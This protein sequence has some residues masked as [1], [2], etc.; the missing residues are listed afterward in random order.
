MTDQEKKAVRSEILKFGPSPYFPNDN[1]PL[2]ALFHNEME[3]MVG[4]VETDIFGQVS[5][6]YLILTTFRLILYKYNKK[7]DDEVLSFWFNLDLADDP[8]HDTE[9]FTINRVETTIPE[10]GFDEKLQRPIFTWQYNFYNQNNVKK[11]AANIKIYPQAYYYRKENRFLDVLKPTSLPD[12][13]WKE[14][15]TYLGIVPFGVKLSILRQGPVGKL[16]MV[17]LQVL[18]KSPEIASFHEAGEVPEDSPLHESKAKR[19]RVSINV[20]E[21]PQKALP[22]KKQPRRSEKPRKQP[23]RRNPK[24]RLQRLK[25]VRQKVKINKQI[26]KPGNKLHPQR[27]ILARN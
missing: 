8:F 19:D 17:A 6:A 20:K 13:K 2:A 16:H 24:K 27:L 18:H 25:L 23:R 12:F 10:Y 3:D 26:K 9:G 5:T 1:L 21:K 22:N 14:E 4:T 15:D 11:E 7:K